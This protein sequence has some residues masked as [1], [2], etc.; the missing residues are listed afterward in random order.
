MIM[1]KWQNDDDADANDDDGDNDHDDVTEWWWFWCQWWLLEDTAYDDL[2][3]L[4]LHVDQT[5]E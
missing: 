2:P 1:M 5:E 4:I 3:A